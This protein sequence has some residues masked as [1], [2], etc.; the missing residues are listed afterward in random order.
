MFLYSFLTL[1]GRAIKRATRQRRK[2]RAQ[3][4]AP[5]QGARNR[6][7]LDQAYELQL[8][9]FSPITR[10]ARRVAKAPFGYP[11]GLLKKIYNP[12]IP[13]LRPI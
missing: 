3:Q 10:Q 4:G 5:V 8:R 11:E 7:S 2:R 1:T 9:R 13:R 12:A 6:S